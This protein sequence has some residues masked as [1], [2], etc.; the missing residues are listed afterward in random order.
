[1]LHLYVTA[2]DGLVSSKTMVH[3]LHRT[4]LH[5]VLMN[6]SS[7]E[8]IYFMGFKSFKLFSFPIMFSVKLMSCSQ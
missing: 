1:M 4:T 3:G 2:L 5:R 7:T 8:S 6:I